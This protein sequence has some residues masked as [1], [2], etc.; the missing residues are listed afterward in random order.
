MLGLEQLNMVVLYSFGAS[1]KLPPPSKCF[2]IE[3]TK[4]LS[5]FTTS[6]RI[7]QSER[8]HEVEEDESHTSVEV[9]HKSSS[10]V[11]PPPLTKAVGI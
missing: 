11:T 3:V 7:L 8:D 10:I 6:I 9:L 4:E 5:Q 1:V 2:D